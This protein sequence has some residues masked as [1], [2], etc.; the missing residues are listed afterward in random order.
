MVSED[1]L[2]NHCRLPHIDSGDGHKR[3]WITFFLTS[4]IILTLGL[5]CWVFVLAYLLTEESPV[6]VDITVDTLSALYV[7]K[8]QTP[9][10]TRS[11]R[12]PPSVITNTSSTGPPEQSRL[13]PSSHVAVDECVGPLCRYITKALRSKLDFYADP[14]NDFY[15]YV[16]GK[17]RGTY[18]SLQIQES[19]KVGTFSDLVSAKAPSSNQIVSFYPGEEVL[20][21]APVCTPGL[22]VKFVHRYLS[23]YTV[24]ERTMAVADTGN[25]TVVIH[26]VPVNA[27]AWRKP[28]VAVVYDL[29]HSA[30]VLQE[31]CQCIS[32][33]AE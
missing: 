33:Q 19:I 7:P 26:Y 31:I 11:K 9:R 24:L 2:F 16:C 27:C 15:Q 10:V 29:Y 25:V 23:P 18:V 8:V 30:A 13:L 14:C 17:F 3:R 21:L 20:L 4:P 12:E 32:R 6:K 28:C 22:C 5:L 1:C